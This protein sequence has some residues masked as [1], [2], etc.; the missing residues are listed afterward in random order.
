MKTQ[1]EK[2]R[3]WRR[4]TK[5]RLIEYKGGECELCGFNEKIP[6][7]Y[8]FHHKDPEKKD[9]SIASNGN[10][11]NLEILKAEVD[12]CLLLCK[13]CHAQ[14][15]ETRDAKEIEAEWEIAISSPWK[16]YDK[17]VDGKYTYGETNCLSCLK[18]FT[19]FSINQKYCSHECQSKYRRKCERPDKETLKQKLD[20][21][22]YCAVGQEYRVSDNTVRKWAKQYSLL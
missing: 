8:D 6:G 18:K 4:R 22:S 19:K 15:H 9:F 3:D 21:S 2:V 5:I 17:V 12:K 7:A 13:I 11:H 16:K 1:S 14:I 20:D 10:C